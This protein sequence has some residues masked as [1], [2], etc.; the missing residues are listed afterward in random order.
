VKKITVLFLIIALQACSSKSNVSVNFDTL[1]PLRV[2]VLPFKHLGENGEQLSEKEN[3]FLVDN[4]PGLSSVQE[5]S[6]A[7][8]LRQVAVQNLES[9]TALDTFSNAI[10]DAKLVHD[11]MTKGNALDVK[12]ISSLPASSVCEIL[13]CDAVLYG[14]ITEW[15]RTY[16]GIET[17]V[18][19]GLK[20][21]LV[22]ASNDS[23]IFS[24]DTKETDR[25]GI[26]RGPTGYSSVVLEPIKGLDSGVLVE[27]G[28]KVAEKSLEP[29][30]TSKRPGFLNT[31][32]PS[33]IGVAHNSISGIISKSNSLKVLAYGSPK[34][35]ASFS[36][37]NSIENILMN[38]QKEGHYVGEFFPLR[39]DSFTDQKI[40]VE[41]RDSYG[42]SAVKYLETRPVS[43]R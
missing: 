17:V 25:R 35:T 43:L 18:S 11:L 8:I 15:D 10:V 7:Q 14:E 41:L 6:P 28:E 32:A 38:E 23:V 27:L 22:R 34:A 13:S 24:S 2:A 4:I 31:K 5:D 1:E 42:R 36:I 37:G 16:Y 39:Q 29:L 20:L 33:I 30:F 21:S 19:V 3:V 40:K 12:K 26:T 9:R